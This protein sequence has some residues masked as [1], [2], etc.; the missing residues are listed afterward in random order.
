[1]VE[2]DGARA[3]LLAASSVV[4]FTGIRFAAPFLVPFL[5]AVFLAIATTPLVTGLQSWRWPRTV[6]VSVGLLVDLLL[7]TGLGAL[8]ARA[9]RSLAIRLPDYQPQFMLL[10]ERSARW[11]SE[12]GFEVTLRSLRAQLDPEEVVATVTTLLQSTAGILARIV[13]VIIIV[14]FLLFEA[15][16]MQRTL[17]RTFPQ[18]ADEKRDSTGRVRRYLVVKTAT[19]LATG[20]LAGSLCFGVGVDFPMLWGLLAYLLNYIPTIGSIIAA[21]PPVALGLVQLGVGPAAAIAI[22][23]IVTNLLIG[24]I[25]EPR[26]MGQALGL[27]PLI[28]LLSMLFWGFLLGPVGA[29]FSAPLTMIAR[30]WL[31]Q[32]HDLQWLG[33]LLGEDELVRA[34][35][36]D[37]PDHVRASVRS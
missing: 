11:L 7:L 37:P 24:T 5:L 35:A 8:V 10:A 15:P 21:L 16:T 14:A 17:D 9:L 27:R 4:L 36:T 31:M 2:R 30:D 29:L 25:L 33:L 34:A 1:M 3:V 12:L 26:I 19:S 18:S 23:Y 32:T 13:L 22:G 28:V 6:A 20:F